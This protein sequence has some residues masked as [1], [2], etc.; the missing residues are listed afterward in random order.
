MSMTVTKPVAL[1]DAMLTSSTAPETD[2]A[3]W[4]FGTF[5][6]GDK[7]IMTTGLHIIYECLVGHTSVDASGA[8]NLNTTGATPKWLA[9]APTNRWAMFDTKVGTVTAL[10]SPLTVVM[11]PG[12]ISGLALLELSGSQAVITMKTAPAGTTIYSKTV[13][14]DGT[15]ITSFYDWFF[16][17]YTQLTDLNITDLP[18]QYTGCELTVSITSSTT[19]GCGVCHIGKVYELGETLMGATVGI[20]S[21]STKTTD[22]FGNTTV[23]R[24]SNS[25]RNSIKL[26]TLKSDFNRIYR[27]LAAL[28]SI[29]CI[30]SAT[31]QSGFEPLI[32]YGF[33]KDFSIDVAYPSHHLTNL[34]IEGLI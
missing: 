18:S 5:V 8:P 32:V 28:D 3:V 34:E 24:R 19:V 31:S 27:L 30:F 23:T 17:D 14:L 25:K 4:A 2:Y 29:A 15:I 9:I 21:Y 1:T 10:A 33:W 11:T 6:A 26:L 13:D 22:A 16:E 20:V 12:A 7:R